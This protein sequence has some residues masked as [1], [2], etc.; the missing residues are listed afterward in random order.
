MA[1]EYTA[2]NITVL[3]D[4]QAVRLRSA[5]YIGDTSFRG[6]HHILQEVLDNSIDECLAGFCKHIQVIIHNDNSITVID[7]GRGIPVDIHPE[8]N[9]SALELVMTV[10]HAGGKFDKST[11]KI[12]GGLHGVGVSVTNALSKF[13]DVKVYREGKIFHQRYE[14]GRKTCEVEVIGE[15]ELTGTEITFLPDEDIFSVHEF[16]YDYVKKRLKELAYLNS[17]I[18]IFLE[19]ERTEVKEEFYF[20][21]GLKEF[22]KDLDKGKTVL[23]EPIYFK[24]DNS[25]SVEIAMQ[26]NDT[27]TT[28]LYSFVNNINTVEGGTHEE[29]FRTALTRVINEYNKK[30]NISDIKL[31][32]DD[33]KEGLTC[34]VSIKVPEPQF[35]GQ[36]KTKL[37]N[38]NVKGLVSSIVYEILSNY[39]EEN[40]A[41]AKLICNKIIGAAKAREAARKARDLARRKTYLESGSLPGKLADCSE[42]DPAKCEIF[43]VEGD[44]AGGCFSEDTKVALLDGRNLTFKELVEEDKKG[45]K[46][47]CYTILK[48]GTIGVGLIE[49]PRKTK[50]NVEVIKIIFDNDEEVICT[51]NHKFMLRNYGYADANE[52]NNGVSIMPFNRKLSKKGVERATIDGYEMVYDPKKHFWIFTHLLSDQYNLR[53]NYYGEYLGNHKHHIDF[54]KLN[55]NPDNIIRMDGWKHF[56]F[57]RDLAYKTLHRD[58]VKEK[59]REIRKTEKFRKKMSERMKN[60]ETSKLL[61][62]NSKEL[63]SNPEYKEYMKKKFLDF[64]YSNE[65]YRKENNRTLNEEQ[66]KYWGKTDN[67]EKQSARVR[68]YFEKYPNKILNLSQKAKEQWNNLKLKEWRSEKT[69]EQWTDEFRRKRKGAYNQTYFYHTIGFMKNVLYSYGSLDEYDKIRIKSK[70][71]N[72]LR[73]DTFSERFFDNNENRMIEAVKNYNHKIKKII[74]LDEK[75]DVYDLEVKE[76]H[77]FALSLG[78]FVHNSAKMGRDRNIQA[79]LPLWGKML[80]VEKSRIDKVFKSEKLQPIISVIGASIGDDFNI[81]KSRYHKIIIMADSDVDGSHINCLLLTFFYRYMRQLIDK[82]YLY[83]AQAPLYKIKQGKNKIYI[84]N[85]QELEKIRKENNDIEVQRFKGLGEMNSDELWETTM[86]PETRILKKITIDDAILA[87][88]MFNILMGEEVEPRRDFIMKHSKEANIDI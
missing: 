7:D 57:H 8:E 34:I 30:S 5:M 80:N 6:L 59:L 20:E 77:N 56:Q 19:D 68:E 26:Y 29:G 1:Q 55:N 88:E 13:L 87:D 31:T 33:V 86:N 84:Y 12:S 14:K 35:E 63:W 71:K 21:G 83:I 37:G 51:P 42:K 81:E 44:S 11:Y 73:K 76:T 4:L 49:N 10:L 65:K 66:K 46:N 72:L 2:K 61:S 39:F 75:I 40:P 53:N 24:K 67:R 32:G 70:N 36:T 85:D 38:S 41:I 25:I 62:K 52:L 50:N 54:N 48:D 17:G 16:D 22:V 23:T 64:Y 79:I 60:P 74:K 9:K 78:V 45:K 47:Y 43:I 82:G 69:K 58:D 15:S 28:K 27:Y 3:K 18:R